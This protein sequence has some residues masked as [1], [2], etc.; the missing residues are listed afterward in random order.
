LKGHIRER[1]PGHWAIVL[2]LRDP[3][4]GTRRRKWHSFQGTK[5]QAQIE[6]ARLISNLQSGQYQEPSKITVSAFLERWLDA[7]R[8]QVSPRTFERYEEIAKKNIM[9]LIGG[10]YLTQL[11]PEHIS[12][13]YAQALKAGRRDGSGGLS[14]R[15]VHH[16][17][18]VLH[19]SLE[20][21]VVWGLLARNPAKLV[22]P[23]R[24]ERKEMEVFNPSEIG[25]LIEH[26]RH[27]RMFIAVVVGV[28]CGLRRGEIAALKWRHVNLDEHRMSISESIEQTREGVRTKETKNGRARVVALP[29]IVTEELRLHRLRQSEELLKIGIRPD[30][31]T[32][33]FTKE[34]GNGLKPS[35]ITNAFKRVLALAPDLRRLRLHDLRHSHATQMLSAGIHPKIAQE[36]LGHSTI[37][38]TL[39]LYSHVLPGMQE[40]AAETVDAA[41]RAAVETAAKR[42]G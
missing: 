24:V 32:Y 27:Y 25:V 22:R 28:M 42:N 11:K 9:P 35:S 36:R 34:D 4:T 3:G 33:V 37:A 7:H 8:S 17:H 10:F 21:A 14:P 29:S 1:S 40:S 23:P 16:M 38:I 41:I 6:C 19:Q 30:D 12:S 26:F 18:R 15:T 39:D 13:A 2:D 31:Q 20:L 5:R